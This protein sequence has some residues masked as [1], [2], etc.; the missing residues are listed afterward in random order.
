M[1]APESPGETREFPFTNIKVPVING[2]DG[3]I[4]FS[5]QFQNL[6]AQAS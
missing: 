6:V 2:L 1:T 4:S 5:D 3:F